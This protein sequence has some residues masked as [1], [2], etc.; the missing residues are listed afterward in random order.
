MK[1]WIIPGKRLSKSHCPTFAQISEEVPTLR[2]RW[3][4]HGHLK[5]TRTQL[6]LV[7]R[8]TTL[9]TRDCPSAHFAACKAATVWDNL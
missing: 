3:Q 4:A 6:V 1:V 5:P 7:S 8:N 2:A 9:P